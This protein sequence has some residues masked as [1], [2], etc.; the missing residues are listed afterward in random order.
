MTKTLTEVVSE[1]HRRL[2][3]LSVDEAA[4]ADQITYGG[5]AATSLLEELNGPP[6][7]MG[8]TW[9]VETVPEALFRPFAWAVS[10]DLAFHYEV[11]PRETR[12]KAIFRI[13]Q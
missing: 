13:R 9:T 10:A 8:F 12:E 1:A 2:N 6:Y 5:A 4:S 7:S 11:A 3:V